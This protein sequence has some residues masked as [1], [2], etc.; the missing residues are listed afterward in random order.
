MVQPGDVLGSICKAHYGTAKLALV[1]AVARYNG[2]PSAD[3]IRAD[4]PVLL[5]DRALL[6]E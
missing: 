6:G 5:P 3:A 2:L 4:D 1:Q